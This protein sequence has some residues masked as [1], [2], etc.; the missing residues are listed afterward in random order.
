[1]L[2]HGTLLVRGDPRVSAHMSVYI[3][4]AKALDKRA[5]IWPRRSGFVG[6]AAASIHGPPLR[7]NSGIARRINSPV[8]PA[9]FIHRLAPPH[10][11]RG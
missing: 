3:K 4:T 2:G 8:G 10:Q 9:T 11:F 1:M 7:M 5:K 6:T